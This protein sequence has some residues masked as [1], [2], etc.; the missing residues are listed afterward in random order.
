MKTVMIFN[1]LKLNSSEHCKIAL[2]KEQGVVFVHTCLSDK[3]HMFQ[4]KLGI[5]RE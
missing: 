5:Y 1:N 2:D 4:R 3:N